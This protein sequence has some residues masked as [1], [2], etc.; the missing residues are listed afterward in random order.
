[1]GESLLCLEK[2]KN[3]HTG[4][5]GIQ[6]GAH[7]RGKHFFGIFSPEKLKKGNFYMGVRPRPEDVGDRIWAP[8]TPLN[9][10]VGESLFEKVIFP[11]VGSG[12]RKMPRSRASG[13]LKGDSPTSA[14]LPTAG[15]SLFELFRAE[16]AENS[17][18]PHWGN[19]LFEL[20]KAENAEKVIPPH[21]GSSLDPLEP[22]P[23]VG[24]SPF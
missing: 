12:A 9:P 3:P 13:L 2:L 14:L 21:L 18:S 15:E 23:G 22:W 16:N 8:W 17:W 5:Q 7:R 19:H 11:H 6:R 10:L 1:M 20:S 4:V 24:E